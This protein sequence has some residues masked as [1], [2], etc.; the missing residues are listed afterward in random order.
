MQL[1]HHDLRRRLNRRSTAEGQLYR[2]YFFCSCDYTNEMVSW[3]VIAPGSVSILV[4]QTQQTFHS[5]LP[6]DRMGQQQH[7]KQ[8]EKVHN[9]WGESIQFLFLTQP[10]GTVGKM[11]RF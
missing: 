2:K 8:K 5:K 7:Q 10:T 11:Q 9:S 6:R 4:L 3:P 1:H